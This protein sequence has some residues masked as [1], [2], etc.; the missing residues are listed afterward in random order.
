MLE[1]VV[2]ARFWGLGPAIA[3]ATLASA[4]YSY[5]FLP[6]AGFG[7]E[8]AIAAVPSPADT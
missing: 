3:A 5:Y 2:A 4:S 6:P 7:I 8:P 1:V